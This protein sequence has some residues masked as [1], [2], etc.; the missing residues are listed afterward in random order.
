MPNPEDRKYIET[1]S[2]STSFIDE[3]FRASKD[4]HKEKIIKELRQKQ[5]DF[6][7]ALYQLKL[8]K[9]VSRKGWNGR[10]M[11]IKIHEQDEHSEMTMPYVYMSTACNNRVPWLASQADLLASDWVIVEE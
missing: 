1:K 11:W 7:E 5:F 9:K 2:S 6:S 8:G 10:G 4:G 3:V